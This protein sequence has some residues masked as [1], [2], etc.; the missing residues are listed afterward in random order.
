MA[1]VDPTLQAA[2]KPKRKL[3]P[4]DLMAD[5]AAQDAQGQ[6]AQAA[7]TSTTPAPPKQVTPEMLMPPT[8]AAPANPA[9]SD[10]YAGVSLPTAPTTNVYNPNPEI[11]TP[12]LPPSGPP[13]TGNPDPTPTNPPPPGGQ[14]HN[15]LPGWDATKWNDPN[16]KTPK[17][18]IGRILA[19]YPPSAAGL[20]QAKAEIEATGLARVTGHDTITL[21][22]GVE[23][24]GHLVDVGQNFS[25][26]QNMAWWWGDTSATPQGGA[27][28]GAGA[29]G[30]TMPGPMSN[31]PAGGG[32]S[33]TIRRM[34][35]QLLARGSAPVTGDDPS[36]R[37]Q[38][39]PVSASLQR[40]GQRSKAAAAERAAFQGTSVGGAGG[41]LDAEQASI[42]EGVGN[43]QGQLM[44]QFV[45]DEI[46]ARRQ[47]VMN[48]L[49]FAQGE[50]KMALEQQLAQ[51]NDAI[52]RLRL[53]Q[54][55][56]QFY[57]EF[58]RRLGQDAYDRNADYYGGF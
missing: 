21:A 15:A 32:Y 52:E 53:S 42:D 11:P 47:D 12:D 19:K 23:G 45:G 41:G 25:S 14:L 4:E 2:P 50:E 58:G 24:G 44:F 36:I 33:D 6:D 17:Y 48:A 34:I 1:Y 43:Q 10:P 18:V 3:R 54:Q 9:L 20:Q 29:P 37:A 13:T 39:D 27:G 49:Q 5:P 40:G 51:M 26:G 7:E 28:G 16:H 30:T 38:F 55:N 46:A 35:E 31:D 22:P 57:D 8:Q 56:S